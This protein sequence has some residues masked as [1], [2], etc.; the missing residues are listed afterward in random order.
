MRKTVLVL[1]A[2]AAVVGL[3]VGSGGF[4]SAELDR[5][6]TANVVGDEEAYMSLA[7]PSDTEAVDA[8]VGAPVETR[9]VTVTN[10]FTQPIDV[11]VRYT[12]SGTRNVSMAGAASSSRLTAGESM[13]V[14]PALT[15]TQAGQHDLTVSFNAT[16]TSEG[17]TAKT[18][19]PRTVAL[20][21]DCDES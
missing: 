19:E 9:L 18:T 6:M 8:A 11:T 20:H 3:A 16:A 7:Y 13:D 21:V 17:V 5:A 14:A 12:S 4:T 10:R 15:C 1:C 2:L